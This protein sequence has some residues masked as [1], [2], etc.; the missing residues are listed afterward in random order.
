MDFAAARLNMVES[1]L[2]TNKVTDEGVLDAFLNV[3]RERF[4]PPALHEVAYFDEELPL[5]GNR[6]LMEPLIFAR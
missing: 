3:P 5:G 1:Q 2:R 6:A 4:V